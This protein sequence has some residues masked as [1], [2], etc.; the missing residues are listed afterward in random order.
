MRLTGWDWFWQSCWST[1]HEWQT[2]TGDIVP[3]SHDRYFSFTLKHYS[4]YFENEIISFNAIHVIKHHS[5]SLERGGNGLKINVAHAYNFLATFCC[6]GVLKK[7]PVVWHIDLYWQKSVNLAVI[8]IPRVCHILRIK[9]WDLFYHKSNTRDY[10]VN[11]DEN[12]FIMLVPGEE[13]A[14]HQAGGSVP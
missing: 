9:S 6:P 12:S 1:F 8:K 13:V 11:R 4:F 7:N 10:W 2:G 5:F 3:S 14:T